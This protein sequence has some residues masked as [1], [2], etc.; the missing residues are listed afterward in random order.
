MASAHT[1]RRQSSSEWRAALNREYLR[2]TQHVTRRTQLRNIFPFQPKEVHEEPIG[3]RHASRKLP[4]ETQSGIDER[5]ASERRDQQ[6]PLQLR[7]WA[8]RWG[9]VRLEDR[10]VGRVPRVREVQPTL[11]N[12]T[13]PIGV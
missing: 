5:P 12:P 3:T 10:H 11:L 2:R 6:A 1:A 8:R 9:V 4:E 7:R 13:A